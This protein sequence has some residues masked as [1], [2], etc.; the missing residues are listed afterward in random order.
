MTPVVCTYWPVRKL[1]RLGEHSGMLTKKFLNNTPSFAM[2]SMFGVLATGW[3]MQLSASQR[4]SSTKIKTIL[5][6]AGASAARAAKPP[7]KISGAT[8][9]VNLARNRAGKGARNIFIVV[10]DYLVQ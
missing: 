3:P 8:M 10:V 5:G 2:R 9:Q 1:L 4:R 6:F 7:A